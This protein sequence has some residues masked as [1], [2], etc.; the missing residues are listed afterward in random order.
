M[1]YL[2]VLSM[3]Y[4][5]IHAFLKRLHDEYVLESLISYYYCELCT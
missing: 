5:L 3:V 4:L 2:N 1:F